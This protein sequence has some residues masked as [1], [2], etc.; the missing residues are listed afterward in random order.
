[1]LPERMGFLVD[2]RTAISPADDDDDDD[3]RVPCNIDRIAIAPTD[4]VASTA[5]R[6]HKR[7][8][9]LKDYGTGNLSI[10]VVALRNKNHLS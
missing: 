3:A 5:E 10:F 6:N 1:M 9:G 2:S 8:H 7:L 4:R